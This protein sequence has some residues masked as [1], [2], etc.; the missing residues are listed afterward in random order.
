[1]TNPNE[2]GLQLTSPE[3]QAAVSDMYTAAS[4]AMDANP[5]FVATSDRL[6]AYTVTSLRLGSETG[7]LITLE[8]TLANPLSKDPDWSFVTPEVQKFVPATDSKEYFHRYM[9]KDGLII[10][11]MNS[12]LPS[13][14]YM[15]ASNAIELELSLEEVVQLV[16]EIR[17][18]TP[19]EQIRTKR[20]RVGK[21]II[22]ILNR[23]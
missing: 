11:H 21:A 23:V 18:W 22:F 19:R 10:D 6:G 9:N 20:S 1:M 7:Q 17:T 12:C 2:E 14:E 15:E 13:E 16:E 3:Y 8:K 5:E 4:Y